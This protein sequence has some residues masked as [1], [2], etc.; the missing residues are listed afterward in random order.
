M[1]DVMED[2][3]EAPAFTWNAKTRQYTNPASG[4]PVPLEEIEAAGKSYLSARQKEIDTA[5]QRLETGEISIVE[6]RD[7]CVKPIKNARLCME[8]LNS[9]GFQQL[10]RSDYE[11]AGINAMLDL[12]RLDEVAQEIS[13]AKEAEKASFT[14]GDFEAFFVVLSVL[15]QAD[16]GFQLSPS[17]GF[18][19]LQDALIKAKPD[20]FGDLEKPGSN[21]PRVAILKRLHA[22]GLDKHPVLDQNDVEGYRK[23]KPDFETVGVALGDLLR[24]KQKQEGRSRLLNTARA[25]P[26]LPQPTF[27]EAR[28][29]ATAISDGRDLRDWNPIEGMMAMLHAPKDSIMQTRFE[30]CSL[31]LG[32]WGKPT[33]AELETL[34]CELQKLEFDALVTYFVCLSWAVE[35]YQVTASLD[36]IIEAIG[37]GTDARRSTKARQ[38]LRAKVWRWMLLFDS[39]AVIG[40]RPGTWRE[41]RDR[42]KKRAKIDPDKLY[43][44]DALLKIIGTRATEQGTFDNSAP[45]KEITFVAGPWVNQFRGNREILSDFGN[46]RAIASIPRGKP[47]GAWAACI[48]FAL[49]QK[50]REQAATAPVARITR[51]DKKATTQKFRPFTRRV[52]LEQLWRSEVNPDEI[53]KGDHPERAKEYWDA[54]IAILKKE[55]IGI[56]KEVKP[57]TVTGYGWQD[58]WLDQPLDIRPTGDS[59]KDAITINKSASEARKRT[60]KNS[61]KTPPKSD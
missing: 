53:L 58:A 38:A 31:L 47:S 55:I 11:K 17:T 1:N 3:Q 24:W 26:T 60:R 37:R 23:D 46:V 40:A 13:K 6:W 4:L 15:S 10:Q 14:L 27:Y 39:L 20:M 42:D 25:P 2:G 44:R 61:P 36:A 28:T 19:D 32:W 16:P 51:G 8:A 34:Q 18:A 33:G 41:P 52:L 30:P 48:G 21:F 7:A 49:N 5:S 50:W 57:L 12:I 43:S 56:Y 9:G 45:P 59:W 22:Q 54:A 29:G 35:E